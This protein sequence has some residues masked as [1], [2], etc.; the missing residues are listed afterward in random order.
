[1]TK[2]CESR[3]L[4]NASKSLKVMWFCP[5]CGSHDIGPLLVH[6][7]KA[8]FCTDCRG[9]GPWRTRVKLSREKYQNKIEG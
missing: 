4:V 6:G 8:V 1:M 2:F 9:F 3:P 5:D 7:E